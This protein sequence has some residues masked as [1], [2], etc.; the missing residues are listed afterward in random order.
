MI[1]KD[2][3]GSNN[4]DL[5]YVKKI[6]INKIKLM[7]STVIF[8]FK[9]YFNTNETKNLVMQYD[10]YDVV[11]KSLYNLTIRIDFFFDISFD[12]YITIYI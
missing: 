10:I 6:D 1:N 12:K 5:I 9:K 4:T 2:E 3:S 8:Q 11:I 7:L